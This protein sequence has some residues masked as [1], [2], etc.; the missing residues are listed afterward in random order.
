MVLSEAIAKPN[1]A[2]VASA[3]ASMAAHSCSVSAMMR[4]SSQYLRCTIP[5]ACKS[6]DTTDI[7]SSH[8]AGAEERLNGIRVKA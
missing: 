2:K 3:R 4:K 8:S 1:S 6:Q 7:I 5:R